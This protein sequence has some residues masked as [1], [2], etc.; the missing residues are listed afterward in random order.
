MN[1]RLDFI[2]CRALVVLALVSLMFPAVAAGSGDY[3]GIGVTGSL[4]DVINAAVQDCED[5]PYQNDCSGGRYVDT[6]ASSRGTDCQGYSGDVGCV[7]V[8]GTS[9]TGINKSDQTW[10]Y[11]I[12]AR[13]CGTVDQYQN[14]IE[15]SILDPDSECQQDCDPEETIQGDFAGEST[16]LCT[17]GCSYTTSAGLNHDEG[18]GSMLVRETEFVDDKPTYRAGYWENTGESCETGVNPED[19]ITASGGT[20]LAFEQDQPNCGTVNGE[21]FCAE[22]IPDTGKCT[23]MGGDGYVC[24]AQGEFPVVPDF[25]EATS[26]INEIDSLTIEG[27]MGEGSALTM[28]S[29]TIDDATPSDGLDQGTD[30]PTAGSGDAEDQA[31]D[32][33]ES[34][35]CEA[36]PHLCDDSHA[37]DL[38]DKDMPNDEIDVSDLIGPGDYPN[39]ITDAA[40]CPEPETFQLPE[41]MGGATLS[42]PYTAFCDFA[43][44]INPLIH[45]LSYLAAFFI[46]IRI[47]I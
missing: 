36:A 47:L 38:P 5:D 16:S 14:E 30:T 35:L 32:Q 20:T 26:T 9:G 6:G 40:V 18:T 25:D 24:G 37:E 11:N 4:Q 23:L 41:G 3:S 28:S 17:G 1:G 13:T 39:V 12:A 22:S 15:G 31:E 10:A 7:F 21:R 42:M 19:G 46:G 34:E 43:I 44:Y 29:G 33:E 45:A 8:D 2:A 27:I